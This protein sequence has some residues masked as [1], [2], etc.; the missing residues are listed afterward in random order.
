MATQKLIRVLEEI[1]ALH[2][3]LNKISKKKT[4]VLIDNAVDEL[5]SL[6]VSE[7][8]YVQALEQSEEK[9]Q[10]IVEKWFI[11]KGIQEKE[12]TLTNMIPF[13]SGKSEKELLQRL[14]IQLTE[15]ITDLK[16]QEQLNADLMRQSLHF[17]QMML[18]VLQPMIENMNY[19]KEE[20]HMK[21]SAFDS[22]V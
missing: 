4:D 21:R 8:K 3:Q 12:Y 16:R 10:K 15:A 11:S 7:N 18:D 22:K 19:G 17:N 20:H 6:L 14:M 1:I 2:N 13:I 5:Q 9:R